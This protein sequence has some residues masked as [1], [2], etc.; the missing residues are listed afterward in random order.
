MILAASTHCPPPAADAAPLQVGRYL[1]TPL[2]GRLPGGRFAA[3]VSIR[4]GCGRATP[5][6]VLRLTRLFRSSGEAVAHAHAEAMRWIRGAPQRPLA[7]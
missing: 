3:S 5:E 7:A 4:P 2:I 6:R 1:V